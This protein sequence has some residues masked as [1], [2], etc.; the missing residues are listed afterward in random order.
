[1]AWP[2]EDNGW[3]QSDVGKDGGSEDGS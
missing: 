2:C 1:V 3:Y